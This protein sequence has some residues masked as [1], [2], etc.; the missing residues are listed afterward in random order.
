MASAG[1]AHDAFD[2]AEVMDAQT[3]I[4]AAIAGLFVTAKGGEDVPG[5]MVQVY[6]SG[7]CLRQAGNPKLGRRHRRPTPPVGNVAPWSIP[8]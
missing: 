3:G 5:G 8:A 2:L 6:R 7:V 4:F 1:I